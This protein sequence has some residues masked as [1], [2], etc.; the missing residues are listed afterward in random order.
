MILLDQPYISEFLKRTI[1]ENN[2][3]AFDSGNVLK[4]G[5]LKLLNESEAINIMAK[6]SG[7]RICTT[8]E[9]A[10][11]WIHKNLNRPL[12]HKHI[13]TFKDKVVFRKEIEN[14]FPKFYFKEVYL[15]DLKSMKPANLP[16]PCII[17][18]A[19]GFFSM[20]VHKVTCAENWE[21]TIELIQK[22]VKNI[23][24]I[25]PEQVLNTERFIIE[26]VIEGDEFAFD[27]YINEKGEAI[28]L[29]MMKHAFASETD[30]S[31]RLYMVSKDIFSKKLNIFRE[32][33]QKIA[34]QTGIKNFLLHTEIRIDKTGEIIPI[35]VNPM[36]FGAWCTSA[37]LTW[38][39]FKTNSYLNFL[40]NRNPDWSRILSETDEHLFSL[41]ILDNNTGYA[42]EEIEY[43]DFDLLLQQFENPIEVRKID[44]RKY[45][46]F[47]M[48]YL[49][50][51]KSNQKEL[52]TILKSNLREFIKLK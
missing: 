31:D 2:L 27:S 39:A 50:T 22:D 15:S 44:F 4:K 42:S 10:I 43:F 36:R 23:Q 14:L 41:V 18:P 19:V 6:N 1:K 24:D 46:I 38:N 47:G 16:M 25:Y 20:G 34:L 28:I 12:I 13:N 37:E 26:E 3:S 29:G 17:K 49:K 30:V 7:E 8:S 11:T 35:E 51:N 32:F 45:P 33:I 9:N 40:E 21:K 52:E 48:V 5:E